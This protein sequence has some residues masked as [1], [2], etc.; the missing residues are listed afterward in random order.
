MVS[1]LLHLP[2]HNPLAILS[3]FM[4]ECGHS[5]EIKRQILDGNILRAEMQT[6]STPWQDP[7]TAA[8]RW[9]NDYFRA[10][11]ALHLAQN[12][13]IFVNHAVGF[14]LTVWRLIQKIAS[15]E[16][17]Q[18]WLKLGLSQGEWTSVLDDVEFEIAHTSSRK[19]QIACLKDRIAVQIELVCYFLFPPFSELALDNSG[20]Y[21]ISHILLGRWITSLAIERQHRPT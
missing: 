16:K 20:V 1:M 4:Q 10:M 18:V 5:A 9:P 6:K 3:L 12:N 14:E 17:L 2:L 11:S 8:I 19:A 7:S 21:L 15:E 13:L